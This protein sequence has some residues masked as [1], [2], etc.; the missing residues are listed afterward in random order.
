M[1]EAAA[2][3]EQWEVE[4]L[5][6]EFG[7]I[8]KTRSAICPKS[9]WYWIEEESKVVSLS[10]SGLLNL[11]VFSDT[12]PESSIRVSLGCTAGRPP[13]DDLFTDLCDGRRLLELLEGL[14][15]KELVKERGFTRVH[16]L[17]NVNRVLQILQ[18]NNVDLVNIGGADIVDG[19]HKLT[20]GLIWSIILHWQVKDVMKDVMANLKQT[21]SEKILLSWVRQSTKSY[22]QVNI[23]NFSSSWEDGLAFNA[24][25]HSHRP[26]LFDWDVVEQMDK[27]CDRLDHAFS[28]SEKHL[29]I[30]RL[31][32]PEDVA[33]APDKKSII[34]YITS[35]FQVLPHGV[36]MEAIE[37]VETLP[38][39]V[40][41]KE[42]HFHFQ[43]QQ[44]FSQQITVS[45]AHSQVRSP[46]PSNKLRYKSYAFTQAAYVRSPEQ[47]GKTPV[48]LSSESPEDRWPSPAA[49]Q[50]GSNRLESYQNS[51]EEVLTWLLSAEDN[52]QAQPPI[53]SFVE[54]VKEQFHTH[55]GYMIELTAHQ[56]SVGNVLKAGSILLAEGQ[57][58]E[59]EENEVQEQMNLLN[60]RWEHLRVASMERQSRLH[61][62]LMDLQNQ[63]LK[64]LSTWLDV[65][66]A[67]IKQMEAQPLGPKIEHLKHQIEE[68]KLLQEDL[69]VEQVR[70]NSLTHM[71]VVVDESS[72]ESATAA[73]EEKLQNL[74]ERWAAICKWTEERWILLQKILR[75]WQHFIE[76]QH[77][78]ESWLTQKEQVFLSIQSSG[79]TDPNEV[80]ASLRKLAILKADIELKRQTMD[81]LCSLVQDLLSN[82]RNK[83]A[84]EKLEAQ[85]EMLA[86]RWDKLVQSLHL[87]STK[88]SNTL[89]ASQ[90]ETT[91]TTVEVVKHQKKVVKH[92]K[93][94]FT[95]PPPQKKRQIVVDSELRKR[96]DVDFTEIHSFMTRS[97]ATLQNP[98]FSVSR[99]EG[100]VSDLYDKVLA[101][102]KEKP[103]KLRKLQEAT[104]SAQALVDQLTSDGQ[105]SDD[106]QQASQQLQTR[107]DEF[108]SLLAERLAWLAYQTKVLAFYNLFHN[109]EQLVANSEN[110]LKIQQP[111]AC[112]AEP[113]R[114]QLERCRP[115]P[116]ETELALPKLQSS[117]NLVNKWLD[118]AGEVGESDKPISK[119]SARSICEPQELGP[120]PQGG[121][122]PLESRS[123]VERWHLQAGGFLEIRLSVFRS[124]Y[125]VYCEQ[126]EV[127]LALLH[128]EIAR[129]SV[130]EPEVDHLPE[131]LQELKENEETQGL[132]DADIVAFQDHYQ[133]VLADLKAREKQLVLGVASSLHTPTLPTKPLHNTS[134]LVGKAYASTG[135]GAACT[136][137]G[138]T[139][140]LSAPMVVLHQ[141]CR[142]PRWCYT[143]AV[144]TQNQL[145]TSLP[146]AHY[147]D[148]MAALMAWLQ[149]FE[150][151]IP[152]SAVTEYPVMEQRLKDTMAIQATQQEHQSKKDDLNNMAEQ[153]YQKAPPEISQR[154][155][156]EMD[157]MMACWR[158]M[159]EQLGENIEK[160]QEHMSKLEQFQNDSK[161]LQK[162]MAEVDVFLNEEWPALGD[163]EALEKQLEQ[164]IALVNDIHTVQPSL[165]GI[166]EVGQFLK[167]EAEPPFAVKLQKMLDD[168]NSQWELICKQAYAKKS[169]LKG[170]LDMTVSLK[171]EMQEMQEWITQ[172]E[173]DYLESD[174]RY[175][176]PEELHTAV[177]ELKRA[178]EEIHQ[179][180]VKVN[181]LEDKVNSF[182]AKAPPTAHETLK[183]ELDGLTSNYQQLCS[184]LDGKYKTLEEVWACWCELLC[185][186]EQEN[187]WM[188]LLEQKLNEMENLQGGADKI[189]DTLAS[190]DA[191]IKE[192]PEYNRNQIRELSQTLMD[193]G[194]LDEL[195]QKKVE[196]YNIRWDEL[197][198]RALQKRQQLEKSLQWKNENDKTLR[199]IQDSLKTTD[200][201]LTAYLADGID[202]AQ[203]P[204][205]AQKIQNEL[206]GH[207]VTLDGM[208][209]LRDEDGSDKMVTEVD[210]TYCKLL[211]VKAKFR[212]FQKPAN[213]DQRLKECERVLEEVKNGLG[214]LSIHSVEY[215]VVQSQLEQCMKLYKS[216]SE[217]KSEVETVIKTGR[218]IVQRQQTEQPKELDERLTSLKLIYNDLGSKVTEGKQALE[219]SLKLLRK[220][221]K[222]LKS[223]TEWL[224]AVDGELTCRSSVE[225][226]PDD[227]EAELA[228][229]KATHKETEQR[230]SQ[231][232]SVREL[233][234]TLKPLLKEES[235]IDD[236]VSLLNCNWIAVTS[237]C[238]QWLNMLLDYQNQMNILEQNVAHINAWI[239]GSENELDKMETRGCNNQTIKRLQAELVDMREKL[240]DVQSLAEDIIK[241]RGENCKSQIEPKLNQLSQRFEMIAKRILHGQASS[242]ELE[243]YHRQANTW[244]LKLDEEIKL[245]ESIKEDDF[246]E[247]AVVDESEL[248]DL[249]LKGENLIKRTTDP[250]KSAVCQKHNLLHDKYNT[251]KNLKSLKRKKALA[252]APQWYQ[253]SKRSEDMTQWLDYIEMTIA[254]LDSA[255]QSRV[256]IATEI[257]KQRPEL[258]D[259][260][261]LGHKLSENGFTKLVEPRLIPI[262]KR[263]EQLDLK[264]D[265]VCQVSELEAL[266]QRIDENDA[267]L[268]SVC[269]S[270][271][272]ENIPQR[273]KCLKDVK[274][275]LDTLESSVNKAL[276]KKNIPPHV[277]P[278]VH[279]LNTKWEKLKKLYQDR[280]GYFDKCKKYGEVF[281]SIQD[282][283]TVAE[284]ALLKYEEDPNINTS[285]IKKL[286]EDLES[287]EAAVKQLNALG[288]DLLALQSRKENEEKIKKQLE[289]INARWIAVFNQLSKLKRRQVSTGENIIL[290]EL[291]DELT[292]FQ[293]W[294]DRAE[295]VADLPVEPGNR[296]QLNSAL[297]KVQAKVAELPN[298]M[299][300]LQNIKTKSS[301][302]PADKNKTL[303]N[304]LKIINMRF[305]KVSSN[306]P[307]K[308]QQIENHLR[309]LNAYHKFSSWASATKNL[310][311]QSPE[312]IEHKMDDIQS[313][314]PEIETVL[315]K[316]RPLYQPERGQFDS[317]S[318]DWITIQMLLK[319]WKNKCQVAT[320]S[321]TSS[322]P[323]VST[324]DTFNYSSAELNDWLSLLDHMI[325][326]HRV[327]VG[328]LSDISDLTVKLKSAVKDME[329]RCPQLNKQITA[330]ENLKNKTNNPQMRSTITD[331]IEKLQAHWED[332]HTKLMDRILQL[333]NMYQDSKEWLDAQKT[334]ES[335]IKQASEKLEGLKEVPA[336]SDQENFQKLAKDIQLWQADIDE[337]NKLANKLLVLY[338]DDDT[339]KIKQMT[340][341]MN[342]AWGKIKKGA[343]DTEADLE[344][345]L[346]QMHHFYADLEMFC[347]WL[348]EA[349]TTANVLQDATYKESLLEDPVTA[350]HLLKQW[351]D[352]QKEIDTQKDTY[353]SLDEN[354]QRIVASLGRTDDAIVLQK[355]LYNVGKR[356]Q[357]LCQKVYS[358][359]H[360]LDDNMEQWKNFHLSLQGLLQWLQLKRE[361][362]E[363]QKPVGGDVPAVHQ[364]LI[365]HKDFRRELSAK[366][367]S[368]NG[369]LDN[370]KT[371]LIEMPGEQRKQ[372]PVERVVSSEERNQNVERILRKEA[373][374]VNKLWKNL[375]TA[376]ADWQQQLELALE[377][378]MEIQSTTEQLEFKLHQVEIEKN[379]WDPVEDLLVDNLSDQFEMVKGFQETIA[380]IQDDVNHVNKLVSQF[381]VPGIQLSADNLKRNDD[382]NRRWRFLQ[383][384]IE[385][386]LSQLIEAHKD[387][388]PNSQQFLQES[389]Q[390]PF[391]RS[392]SP[393]SVPYYINSQN[394]MSTWS[395]QKQTYSQNAALLY[396]L[397]PYS[398]IPYS[399]IPY[400][401]I[402]YSPIPYFLIPYSLIP[403]SPIPYSLI[404][405]SPIPYSPIPY[406]LIPYSLIPYSPIPYSL[407]P[408]SPIPYSPI[409]YFLIPYS[410]IPYSPIP[411]SLIPY[412]PI[413]Y[414]PIP[415]FLIPYS[416]I[417]YSPIPY[418]LIPYSPIPY[419]PIPY[420]LIP[421]SL[422]PYSPIPYSLIPYS[423]IPYSPIPYFLI[424]YSLI[425]YSPIP[426]SLIPYSPIPY[427][428]IPYFLIPY[429]LIPYS[430]IPYSLIPYSPIP[431]SPIPYFLIPYSL[432]PY[433]PIPYSLIPYS[434]I[435]YSPI[436]YFLIPYSLIPYSPIPYSL[437]PYSPIPY[438]PIPYFLIPY[439]LIPYSPIPYSL[440]PYSP[441]PYSPIPYFLI[442]YSLIPYSPIPYSLI[443]YS[444]I[445]YS[446]I[447]YFLIPYSLIPYSPIPYSLIPYSPIPYSPIPYFLIPYSLIPYSPIPYSLIP[448]SPIPYSP[449][450][451]FLIPYSLI[452]YSPIPYSLIPYSPIPYSPIPYFLIPYSLIPYS[453]IPYSLIPYSPIPYSPIPYFLIPY[454]LIP[455][456]PIPYSL[457]PYSPIPYSPIPYFLIPYSLI[458][459][460]PIPY[461]L[462]PYSPIPY[463]P[464][465][466]FLI[467]YSLIPY[468][469]IPYSLIPYSPIPYSP[470]P[471]F[472]I[473]YSLIPYSPIPY[474]LIPYSPI[475][476][477]PIPYFLI[478]Y[479]LI[480]YSPIPY[481]LIPYSPIPYSPI[482][483]FLIPYS[484]IPYSPIPYSLIPYS[485]IPYSPIPY[486]LIPYS[487]IPYS[488]IPYSLIPYS[489]IPYSPIPYF[490]I[491]YSLIPYSPIPYSLIPYSP[492][493][494]SPIPY[495][496]IPYSLIPYSPIPYSLIPY[497]PIPYSPIP[498]FLIPYSL[499]PYSPIPY[500]LIPYSPIPYS[501]IP[502]FL[503]P[504]SLIPYSPI[505]YSLIP[506]S[507]I[508]YSPIPYFLIPYSLI[509][510]SPI[511]YSLIPYSPIPYSP[512]PYFL[513]PYSL[514]PY[515]PIPYSLIPYS[516]IPYSPIPYFLIPYS[517]IPYS[518]IPYSL[519]PYSPIPYSPIPY[520]LIPYSL[521]PY[522]PIPYSLIPYSPIPYSPIP[523]FLIPYSL[524]P[525]S[526]IPYSLIPYSPIPYSPIPY[527]LIPYSLIPYSPI[528]YSLI[529]YSPIPYSPIPYFL[530]PYSLIPYSPIP[531]SLIPYSPI[532][533]SPIP[534]FLIPYSLIPYS[535]IPYSL[536]P[537]SPIPYSPIPY[538]LIP[539]SLIPYSPIPYSLIPYSPIPY[540]PIPYFLIPYSLIP[541]S[542]IPYSL[543]P[544]SPIP[545]SPIP[546]FLIPY[547][548]IPYSPIPYSLI[549]YSPIPYSPIPYF[550]IPY[551][552]IPYSPIPYSL[553]PYSPI[554]YSPI[555][556]FLIPY[557]LIPYSP[558]PYSLIPYSPIPYSPIPYFLIPYSL[559]PYSPIPYSLIPYSPIPYS[560]IPYF[561][562]PYSL[563]PYSPIPYSLIP[564]SPI[565][566]SPIPY[567]LIP[568]S[569]IPYSPIPYSLI[570]YS[571]IPYSPIPYFLIP[572]SLIPYSPI[573]YSLI[574]YSPIPYSP[575]PYFLI[576]YSLIPYSPIPYSLIPYSPIPYSPIPYFLI[577]YS[578]I[579]YSP[580]PYSL[581]PYSP[582]PY[583]PIP[584][585]LIPYSL[586]PYSP[587]PYSLIPYSPIPYSPIPYF[588]IPYSLIPYSPIPYSLIPYSPIPYSPIPYFLIPYS[589]IPYSPIPYSLIPYSPI[590]YSPIPYFLIPYSLIPYSPIPYSLIPYSPIPYSPIPY[591][592]IPY[593]LIP[594]SPIPYSLIPYSPIPYSPIPYFLIP[595]SLI[596]YSPIPYSLIPYSPIPYSPIPYFLIPYSLIPYSPIPYS[597][598]PYSPIP[599]S[600][601]PYFLIPYSLI[602]YS[603]IP[604]SLIPYSPI[605]YSPIPYFLI[606][607][608]LIPYSPI[609]YSLIPYSPIP[610]SPIPYFL[611][612]YSLIPYSPIPYSLIPYSPIPYSPIPYFLIPYSL[613]PYSPIPYSLIPYSPIPYSPI[614]YF[615]IPYSL[616]PYSPIPYS[617]IPY[618]PIPY[619]PIPYFLIPYSLIPY[620]PIPYSLIPYSPIPYSPIPY[621]LIPYSLI[622]YSPI[623]YSLIPYSPIPYSPIPYFLIPYSLIPYSPIP[624]SLIPYSPIPYSPIPYFL[625][626]YSLIPYSPIP[627]S[628]IPYS[629]IPYSPIPYFLIPYSLIP[630]SPIPYSL[631]PYSPI[632]YSPIP[633]FLIPYSLI[634]YS[635]IPYSLIPYSPIPYSPIPY[636]LIPYS[637]IPYSPIPYSLIPYSPIPYS[638]I[639]Y[640]LI[641]YSL[642]PYSPIPYSLI[643]Y[644]PIPYS[645]IPYFLIPYSL[646]P[647]S[648][649][650]YSLIPYSPIPYSP[651]PYFLIPYSL[652]PYSPIPYSL[653]PYSP[654]PYSP[655]P[656]FLI[657]YSLIPYS[658]I[659]YSLIPY[660]PIPYSPIPYFLI[661]Y[662]L[663]PYS[664]IPYSLI[665]YS[666]IPYSPIPYFLIPYSLIPYS[667]IP[668]S[669]IPYSPIPY[670]LIP[671]SLIPYSPITYTPIPYSCIPYFLI[672]YSPI[673]YSLIPYSPITYTPI[674]YSCIPYFLIPYSPIPY[675]LIFYTPIPYAPIPYSLIP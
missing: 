384:S 313:K 53:S 81:K 73:L 449:I 437:I 264:F 105:N 288:E 451:Y 523:Y 229:A 512:I 205:E 327:M 233:A 148:V 223:L 426:Y 674:P 487:L 108:C 356:W 482:P 277:T 21:S 440:I 435:P 92:V 584:Y 95:T 211:E 348:T 401:P 590:P 172:A 563:I 273:E 246:K 63:Q 318:A 325:T 112:E 484:L 617:L 642:I 510:Y 259:V 214:V 539:Y 396:S 614:P 169:A 342:L 2:A 110:W 250:A 517:L 597:L 443:P 404:P 592:L 580:I 364:Q 536:I 556:Y 397:I 675:S 280:L 258:E 561:L 227:L 176:T 660:S 659:P 30:D 416:L 162:W 333:Q 131:K 74:G 48:T 117:S 310:L 577:P 296:E 411:Y 274:H 150:G 231:L 199:Q 475:P 496:L 422:I 385:E 424:P 86:Q 59:D 555:P 60:S 186:L 329:Q 629:P 455:Y 557:S 113:L 575:I 436:P 51:L 651:I 20:L 609:P 483:Y 635:P 283:L 361:E 481:S 578:L 120:K 522:S 65:T 62:V 166:N 540:S 182:I 37:E 29:G 4:T 395:K 239:D 464:I 513:I 207:E 106:I 28:V 568:Y 128:D 511:P 185:Y 615:L 252:F 116:A 529:P 520:F 633:Y 159:S 45:V 78:F 160:L 605:P 161:T 57:L 309:D 36:S 97:E 85:L 276:E 374:D 338:A 581:I 89:T 640:F 378:L 463:S 514:I 480:P 153:V 589:L 193:G 294:L 656:Y 107:W 236:K 591:F 601:I 634:P 43:T 164:C 167:K 550:L 366:E 332:S 56:G 379:S 569:L 232:N 61:E 100:S 554:P 289:S 237:R 652:I 631:I 6:D 256:K 195:I 139:P 326:S 571:P 209:K 442:P 212:L 600:P 515:S 320:E 664:P 394:Y 11:L 293:S 428:P 295:S 208:K 23:V 641:P 360:Y 607:Y 235:L 31:L 16:S 596:P 17:N 373:D 114:I 367:P 415:Y 562:I 531:Y 473:P 339:S 382:L 639:P 468:S 80:A 328:Y 151:K 420:F 500:S 49:F 365:I 409:P 55:E 34:M 658:P 655:I 224:A 3:E 83:Q 620:S 423:P 439:S 363:Q 538:F 647:Y 90:T 432:I 244:L 27:A 417:P 386:H 662:S 489:P 5:E 168:L 608:S 643:P 145:Q 174:F 478:P 552:L 71:V 192:H 91:H 438:S 667:P 626:P 377:R 298:K 44:R 143:S 461:S 465:P 197:M 430:P 516:P 665:P 358:M 261:S 433:S 316:E 47:T 322:A 429:S 146:P 477:S 670:S 598:I 548:L 247:D 453:P 414:S 115:A 350:H 368:I 527:F 646:I 19:N 343:G 268:N 141:R 103:E 142:H 628:L 64:Q 413:P 189:A 441:I 668:Y 579:P 245:G 184:R 472:L 87:T 76:E 467:P 503:I 129:L 282:W 72:G 8:I 650:P 521:I 458:P 272:M 457:I 637:L 305:A 187:T 564:Y 319:E 499:I 494:Y 654:I 537:Y 40:I 308:Q 130:L 191:M 41:S 479:S 669:L 583:S 303:E 336:G 447:P 341:N 18:K 507:P 371:F 349:E 181:L 553:I 54:E 104:R 621:F 663:I 595:Y 427:S 509:P 267:L 541:Y 505:P 206:N 292:N 611:I 400:S 122:T 330:A 284:K 406:F 402:P 518:P 285:Q 630:Y 324:I 203:I 173:E 218:Q 602:P 93:E 24:L 446:P 603:P 50:Q 666:P 533:Y 32:D 124:Q 551:S 9:I 271:I 79:T 15:G 121:S 69:E 444:P 506:Y 311:E 421:Y 410:L 407:I 315:A 138:A 109:L 26:E 604:Y 177:E 497:S 196:D 200:R 498:Y 269:W 586:I 622:P 593:S 301:S 111:P 450:P 257:E 260:R 612:P 375:R 118:Q 155:H 337:T 291:H 137:G 266:L 469:P 383:I 636:F 543:I 399:L 471:Y 281:K 389:V 175:K 398:P 82:I 321:L 331:R 262:N 33:T 302:L 370:V 101:I 347:N 123:G 248:M 307:E 525:Y 179:K 565:P 459:Y 234:E 434:P 351:Q 624:Y 644:S 454:S 501:P 661:P 392:V 210:A 75:S 466:Y 490:L 238:E 362:L 354:G 84:S 340:E 127:G 213:F 403:Y 381:R 13:I 135:Q 230:A 488:P 380:P 535:P 286:Q 632:P 495:F 334:V 221:K 672:P 133:N 549:P 673:P 653:I 610:Y 425:P 35:L 216:L 582:I 345:R 119:P 618:S 462:I 623:P 225:G 625:I 352:L 492:I 170:G 619:S 241:N 585:F 493:P 171:K 387:F 594:Y 530:I 156:I 502:Y 460:S 278:L 144:G 456:S 412:S 188:D 290:A 242:Q 7:E 306:L 180:K 645:P 183:A 526:P 470:I 154:Y 476:Y 39:T 312:A 249:F 157:N 140:G 297:E 572:Y 491:P 99:K 163:S 357:D 226:M 254:E 215:D 204:Q 376:A 431:Y 304:S 67:R 671:Y 275:T 190:L 219:K 202:A 546:Y 314:K 508:P 300:I 132:P 567:F 369:A 94:G 38:H 14:T 344:A 587:I 152:S 559:I 299:K 405:Y 599:Y 657:P 558:I 391:E 287:Q 12:P 638:P 570:P 542:P 253:F 346:Q 265:E 158:H 613:I 279:L 58:T 627:Y 486:F 263:W 576:P 419:S 323:D 566:Y 217:V 408:Y 126:T 178:Q 547:S 588:L 25:I 96:F 201:H 393:N 606:P 390:S 194:V 42:K 524:I 616:I 255:N 52:L 88:L 445:P 136:H 573:P 243:E 220:L 70:V 149:Q 98:E 335:H 544:Y 66:E 648:P 649:I 198:Q 228:W 528:P 474:S 485:P 504:Y 532:P 222:D 240:A 353:H 359:R 270:D 534:Y 388:G 372:T 519:I 574:P 560:P 317:L 355:Q 251:L 134:V 77:M 10:L 102:D 46:S 125:F 452:P 22:P 165:N 418:S 68:H 147:K 545:Y 1:A 448:Y